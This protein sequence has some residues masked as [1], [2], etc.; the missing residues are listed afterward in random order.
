MQFGI[1]SLFPQMFAAIQDYGITR[2][3]LKRQIIEINCWDPRDFTHNIHRSVDARPYGGGPGMVMMVQPLR[4]ALLK[5]KAHLG[6][7]TKVIY[8]SPQGRRLDHAG[9]THLQSHTRLILVAG[10]YEGVDQRFLD[11]YV[12]EQWSIGDYVL[13]GGEL[14]AMVMID[15]ITRLLPGALGHQESADNDSFAHGL[16]EYPHY[17]RPQSIDNLPVPEVLLSGDHQA[18]E[19][20]RAEQA[21][22]RTEQL[23][24]DLLNQAPAK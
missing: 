8:L 7:S 9:L 11:K 17:T 15:A 6:G 14:A 22:K 24:P 2:S 3:A 21:L 20:W 1:I 10:R 12:D 4:D 16:L 19:R 13:S 5:A 23:R 18:I